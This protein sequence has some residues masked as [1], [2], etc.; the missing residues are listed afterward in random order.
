MNSAHSSVPLGTGVCLDQSCKGLFLAK[1]ST[2]LWFLHTEET[3]AQRIRINHHGQKQQEHLSKAL[4][5]QRLLNNQ[6]NIWVPLSPVQAWMKTAVH[7]ATRCI[8]F[9]N[10]TPQ[11][12]TRR[13]SRESLQCHVPHQL[14]RPW[15]KVWD[16]CS[17][18][19]KTNKEMGFIFL[20]YPFAHQQHKQHSPGKGKDCRAGLTYFY[21][22]FS[23][24]WENR[25]WQEH[26]DTG[27]N[28]FCPKR[29]ISFIRIGCKTQTS[30]VIFIMCSWSA[31][32][33]HAFRTG[34]FKC[35]QLEAWFHF[36]PWGN[37]RC[38][39]VWTAQSFLLVSRT[40]TVGKVP[41]ALPGRG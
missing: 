5:R 14:R 6:R 24:Y 41:G 3:S 11:T 33:A 26:W 7:W 30:H 21:S 32:I 29:K 17:R 9:C 35:F 38:C 15:E 31:W 39:H 10:P 20:I 16:E 23:L 13:Q 19:Y 12:S 18:H 40:P 2:C 8:S 37:N 25:T 27:E 22:V 36:F 34:S 28:L 4:N 1:P